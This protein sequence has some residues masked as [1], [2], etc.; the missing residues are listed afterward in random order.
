M[1]FGKDIGN[2][3]ELDANAITPPRLQRLGM[4]VA[5]AMGEVQYAVTHPTGGTVRCHVA[6]PDDHV[7]HRLIA[8]QLQRYQRRPQYLDLPGQRVGVEGQG[9]AIVGALVQW[10]VAVGAEAVE[11]A[12][13]QAG[14]LG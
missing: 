9:F 3:V 1:S 4:F 10:C 6:E 13:A 7:G 8:R 12:A 14:G 5:V 2:I 11:I